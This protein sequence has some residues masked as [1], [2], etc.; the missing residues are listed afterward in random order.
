M[1]NTTSEELGTFLKYVLSPHLLH[2]MNSNVEEE[3]NV[4]DNHQNKIQS[5]QQ[6]FDNMNPNSLIF[7]N[8]TT[9]NNH[10]VQVLP[11]PQEP[12]LAEIRSHIPEPTMQAS[13]HQEQFDSIQ[14]PVSIR[15][16]V[17]SRQLT[18]PSTSSELRQE[19]FDSINEDN[20]EYD[21]EELDTLIYKNGCNVIKGDSK[22]LD[23][24]KEIDNE[25]HLLLYYSCLSNI[26]LFLKKQ[27][28]YKISFF[29]FYRKKCKVSSFKIF[30]V[31]SYPITHFTKQ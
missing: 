10:N 26:F 2:E 1:S 19:P 3:L 30:K 24:L 17:P 12:L 15:F 4:S 14:P 25:N 28:I 9:R 11:T 31:K 27:N 8:L 29:K 22:L 5:E 20:Y 16:Q 23:T 7:T 21:I 18:Q 13:I 6:S